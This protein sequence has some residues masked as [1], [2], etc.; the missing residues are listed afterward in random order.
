MEKKH[1]MVK[2]RP[3]DY[4]ELTLE[5]QVWFPTVLRY[6]QNK[7]MGDG[8]N[9]QL[10]RS[11]P[12]IINNFLPEADLAALLV[13]T[14]EHEAEF[15]PSQ[16]LAGEHKED[17]FNVKSSVRRS[18]IM[19]TIEQRYK[20]MIKSRIDTVLP[21]VL[22]EL[23]MDSFPSNKGEYQLTASNDG[24]FF[25]V[26]SDRGSG[27]FYTEHRVLT[28]V[29]YF[30]HEPKAFTGG[31]L[32]VYDTIA[33][34]GHQIAALKFKTVKPLQN[35]IVFFPSILQHEVQRVDCPSQQFADSRF[36]FNGWLH[37]NPAST[38]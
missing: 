34:D 33:V 19:T 27:S 26:H 16:V 22:Y 23:G 20:D 15:H 10:Q 7:G 9:G 35:R 6:M 1:A 37:D 3:H 38:N 18:L 32:R 13:Y 2:R 12:V 4:E 36:T 21:D 31:D 17:A 8:E 25:R 24:E 30:Y 11:R 14:L 5:E 29:Y 28:Y